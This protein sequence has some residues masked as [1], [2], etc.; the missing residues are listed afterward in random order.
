MSDSGYVLLTGATGFLGR[1][2]L[3]DLLA[4]GRRVA[5]LVRDARS[6]PAAE[7]I[8]ELTSSWEHWHDRSANPVV[9]AGDVSY[10][11][12]GLPLADR[13]WLARHCTAVVHAAAEVSLRRS[14]RADPWKTNV[15]GAQ[16]LLELCAVL[17]IAELHHISTAFVCGE[18]LGPIREDELDHGQ[19]FHNDYEKSKYEAERL[20]AAGRNLRATIYRPSVIVGDS[21]TGWTSSYHGFY[22]FLELGTRLAFPASPPS[23]APAGSPAPAAGATGRRFLPLRLP[24][25][26]AEPRNLVPVD[27]VAQAIVA[28]VNQP[29][30]HGKT[31]HL[32]ATT[33]VSVREVKEVAEEVLAIDGVCFAEPE[34]RQSST[35]L[36]ELFLDQLR[37]YWPYLQ[38]DPVFD[39]RNT[40]A[41][42]P[43]LPAPSIDRPLLARLIRFAVADEWGRAGRK[44]PRGDGLSCRRYVEGFFPEAVRRS[45]LA[46]LPLAV[47]V[48][49]D[50]EGVGGGQWSVRLDGAPAVRP[51]LTDCDEVVYRM[52]CTTFEAVVR[53]RLNPQ[54]AFLARQIEISGDLEK[55]LKLAVL[56]DHFVKECPYVARTPSEENDVVAVRT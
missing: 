45:R 26:G 53:G 18:R 40:R 19:T 39:C 7:R 17:G 31:Y 13:V 20:I 37:E 32:V 28:L 30:R 10:P 25:T 51:G 8:R 54:E 56:F 11:G 4:S 48:G 3:R 50:I 1:Y 9:L 41:A 6:R 38:G 15:E 12:L 22:R 33:P 27:W 43:Q 23:P 36:E 16:H 34:A 21:R 52:S 47:T 5:V 42:L 24:F 2:L 49:L 14:L 46:R 35:P 44:K 29:R 55:G